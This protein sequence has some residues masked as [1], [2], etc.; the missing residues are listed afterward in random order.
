MS[1]TADGAGLGHSHAVC[2]KD[3]ARECVS[4]VP[5]ARARLIV[6]TASQR[7]RLKK[8]AYSHTA[9][10]QLVV[11]VRIVV[12]AAG[13]FSNNAIARSQGVVVDTVRTWRNRYAEH[14]LKDRPRSGRPPRFTPLQQ[15]EIKA[16]ACQLPAE[17][18]C[19]CRGG[20][21]ANWPPR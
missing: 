3:L 20:A 19:R 15:T 4:P 5:V 7:R 8:L 10:Y 11:R 14:G 13:G 2:S 1:I 18:A 17:A 21:A 6:L 9:A 12:Y 16:L